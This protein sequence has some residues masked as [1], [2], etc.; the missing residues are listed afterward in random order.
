MAYITVKEAAKK[1]DISER[2]AQRYCTEGRIAGA[3]KF[4]GAWAIPDDAVKPGDPRK[5]KSAA[6]VSAGDEQNAAG[7]RNNGTV[8]NTNSKGDN[9]TTEPGQF[10][11]KTAMPLINTPFEPGHCLEAV[12][13]IEDPEQRQIAMA[14]YYYF[15][16]RAEQ[17]AQ[18][19][20]LFLTH[21]DMALRLSACW[22][23]AYANLATGHIH[24]ARHGLAEVQSTLASLDENTPPQLRALAGGISMSAAVLLH[25]PLPDGLPAFR[26]HLRL[27][28][29][30]LRFFALYVQAHYAYLQEDYSGSIGVVETALALQTE[31]YPIPTIYLHLVA[32]MDYMSLKQAAK[33]RE[34]L[35]AAWELAQPDDLIEAFGEHHGLLGGMLEAVI[36]KDWPDDFKRI[37]AVTYSFS[38][39]WRK[40]HNPDTGHDVADDLTT[41]EFA[42][43]MLAARDWTNQEIGDHMGISPNTVKRHISTALQKLDITQRKELKQYMLR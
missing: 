9:Q 7:K 31:C 13:R 41:T 39:G 2:L 18:E 28:P 6:A 17:A 27:L 37:I 35:L 10:S 32:T 40:I 14:E 34:H 25:L 15:S 16:G 1:W 43:A 5:D 30:G 38:A 12:E 26:E 36:K 3:V 22:L 8:S 4:S 24:L 29:P 20:E 21:P 11:S 42:V 33:A 19:A 23:Y